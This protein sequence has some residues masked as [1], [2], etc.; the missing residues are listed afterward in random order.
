MGRTV[1]SRDG[2]ALV[3]RDWP[4]DNAR[5]TI[6]IVHG[7]GEHIGRYGHVAASL[8][9]RGWS[10]V[11]YDQRGHGASAGERGRL[12]A[13]DDLL[14]DLALVVD[15]V[16]AEAPGPLCPARAQPGRPRRRALRRRRHRVAEAV[17][18]S[19]RRRAR[20]V[21]A[22]ARHRHDARCKRAL[23]ALLG[24]LTPNLAR[25]QRPESRVDLAR[26]G[27]SRRV[28]RRPARPRPDRAT[29]R[30]LHRRR[31]P[32]GARAGAALAG[33]DAAAL[34]RQRPLRRAGRQ[35]RVRRRGAR[36]TSSRR[37]CSRR[38]STRSSTN[39]SRPRCYPSSV[40]GSIHWPLRLQ[41]A[42]DER[43]RPAATDPEGR[44]RSARPLRRT[45][46]GRRDRSADHA[47]HRGPGEEPD[48]R[49][50]VEGARL[51]RPRRPRRRGLGRAPAGAGPEAR[52]DPPRGPHAGDLLRRAGDAAGRQRRRRRDDLPL[53]PPRQAAR[54]QRLEE[55]LRPVDAALRERPALRPRRRRRR[56]RDLRRAHGDQ[57][58]RPA[59]AS[60]GR[61]ASA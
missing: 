57:V 15:A 44:G 18:A 13:G 45:R 60:P 20:A 56:L 53:R 32:G 29:A 11:G 40:P 19:R 3:R 49:R 26:C 27:G 34:R 38:C 43:T 42:R 48:V 61:A 16:R 33:A 41:G 23:L 47:L 55:R 36:R 58:A 30:A 50:R 37:A 2:L 9:E 52:G 6:V 5:G 14:A 12:A 28:P 1:R 25:R 8:N 54:V 51:H 4:S 59:R 7:L 24:P 31:R 10:V 21:V 46:L 22:G 17:L 39:P 35:R